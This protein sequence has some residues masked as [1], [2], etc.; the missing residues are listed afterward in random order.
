M[1]D[2]DRW[3]FITKNPPANVSF[4]GIIPRE[5]MN[6]YYNAC[7]LFFLPSVDEV[8]G[9]CILEAAAAGKPILLRDLV[10]YRD[11][12]LDHYAKGRNIKEFAEQI[13][14][15]RA[16]PDYAELLRGG[17]LAL[18][19]YYSEDRLLSQLTAFYEQEFDL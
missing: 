2:Y 3:L 13:R 6:E 10:V 7:D 9:M 4:L 11:I 12:F 1:D 5:Q 18:R 19:E 8:F 17:A 14:R 15:V 16:D